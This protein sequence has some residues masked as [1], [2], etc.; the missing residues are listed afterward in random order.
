MISLLFSGE[1]YNVDV[2]TIAFDFGAYDGYEKIE[3]ELKDM[4]IGILGLFDLQFL[5]FS[6]D[7][8][9]MAMSMKN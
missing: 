4:E 8:L 6:H 9:K 5:G 1:A 7:K 2:K 3:K